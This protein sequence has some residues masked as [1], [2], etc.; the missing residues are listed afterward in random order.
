MLSVLLS[1]HRKLVRVMEHQLLTFGPNHL[2][3]HPM[4]MDVCGPHRSASSGLAQGA[5]AGISSR[6]SLQ[7]ITYLFIEQNLIKQHQS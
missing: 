4:F 3:L 2:Y 7:A 5:A 6:F 1:S